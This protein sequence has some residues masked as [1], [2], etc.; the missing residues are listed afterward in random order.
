MCGNIHVFAFASG[1]KYD[2]NSLP[3]FAF[4][5]EAP[6]EAKDKMEHARSDL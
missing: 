3:L 2:Y 1:S 6:A 5:T 4:V